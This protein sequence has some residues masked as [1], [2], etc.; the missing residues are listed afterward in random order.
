MYEFELINPKIIQR[1][2]ES[3]NGMMKHENPYPIFFSVI[4]RSFKALVPNASDHIIKPYIQN[5][6]K[7]LYEILERKYKLR[8]FESLNEAR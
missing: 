6:L 4:K 7:P 5:M 3:I 2:T 1:Y 8:P